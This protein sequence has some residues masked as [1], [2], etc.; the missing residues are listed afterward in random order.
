M[1]GRR[2]TLK[3]SKIRGG[4]VNFTLRFFPEEIFKEG[5]VNF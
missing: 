4:G 1:P 3:I 5:R 2:L